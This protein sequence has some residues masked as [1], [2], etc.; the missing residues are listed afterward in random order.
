MLV[1][2]MTR[3]A[4]PDNPFIRQITFYDAV[5]GVIAPVR[6]SKAFAYICLLTNDK[7]CVAVLSR[8]M[9]MNFM[10]IYNSRSFVPSHCVVS[11]TYVLGSE[12]SYLSNNCFTLRLQPCPF[13]HVEVL[14]VRLLSKAQCNRNAF[15]WP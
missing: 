1:S 5:E 6:Q 9:M 2:G 4:T 7:I 10:W 14:A 13:L 3:F 11:M 15:Q 8:L 12:I